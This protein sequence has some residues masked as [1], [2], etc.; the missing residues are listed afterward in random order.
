M[1]ATRAGGVDALGGEATAG[2][3]AAGE[4]PLAPEAATIL[5]TEHWSLSARAR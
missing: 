2:R 1:D 5:A 4:Q 3:A